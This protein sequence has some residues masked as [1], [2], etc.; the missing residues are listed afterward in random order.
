MP[1]DGEND[2]GIATHFFAVSFFGPA[3]TCAAAFFAT[4]RCGGGGSIALLVGFEMR[5]VRRAPCWL[6]EVWAPQ[7][8]E[9]GKLAAILDMVGYW[10]L[11]LVVWEV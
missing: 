9:S 10:L 4:T 8:L 5:L 6:S 2:E 1:Q 7:V 3:A 11:M